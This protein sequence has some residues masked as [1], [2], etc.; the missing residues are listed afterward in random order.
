MHELFERYQTWLAQHCPPFCVQALEPAAS[1]VALEY[2]ESL[3]N[4]VL[5]VEFKEFYRCGNGQMQA[6][7]YLMDSTAWLNLKAIQQQWQARLQEGNWK[8]HWLPFTDDGHGHHYALELSSPKNRTLGAVFSW[9]RSSPTIEY[10]APSFKAFIT[11][12]VE[13][14]E[15][16]HYQYVDAEEA[17]VFIT[18]I[19]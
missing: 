11:N 9:F 10:L 12:Y 4:H 19:V 3:V 13:D 16:G 6:P 2:L 1:D 7:P 14:L 5:P 15:A 18:E 8:P 17:L